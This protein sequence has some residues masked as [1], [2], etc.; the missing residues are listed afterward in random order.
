MVF[1]SISGEHGERKKKKKHK[2]HEFCQLGLSDVK[3]KKKENK[4][5]NVKPQ[6]KD[7]PKR[8]AKKL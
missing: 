2:E 5:E 4:I 7:V 8:P 1:V 3:R 6:D